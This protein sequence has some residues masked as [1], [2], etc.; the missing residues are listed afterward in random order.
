MSEA[1]NKP[2]KQDAPIGEEEPMCPC[3]VNPFTSLPPELRP[4]PAPKKGSLRRV[5]CPGCGKEYMTNRSADW[6]LTYEKE[7]KGASKVITDFD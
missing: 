7:R 2:K 6:C 1:T 4:R 3:G 5:I